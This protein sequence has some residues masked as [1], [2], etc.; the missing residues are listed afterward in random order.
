MSYVLALNLFFGEAYEEVLRQLVNGLKFLGNW[1]DNWEM[2]STSALS[3]ARTRLGEAPIKLLVE[4]IAVPMAGARTR[5]AW[6]R[7]LRVMAIDGLVLDVPA[8]DDNDAE[9]GRSGSAEAPSPFP[10]VRLVALG[11]C[12]TPAV[13]DAAFGPVGTGEQTLAGQLIPRFTAGMLVLADRNFYSYQAWQQA[14]ATG[15]ALL[16]RVSANLRLPV[17]EWL[18]EG[19]YRSVLINPRIRGRRR[20]Q[21]LA[22]RGRRPG[23]RPRRGHAGPGRRVHD[24]QPAGQWGAVLPDHHLGRPRVRARGRTRRG[25][26]PTLGDRA[27]L[28]RDR[29]PPNR[30]RAGAPRPHT[31]TRQTGDLV[32]AARALRDTARHERRRRYRRHRPRRPLLHAKLPRNPPPNSQP[33][34]LFPLTDSPTRSPKPSTRSPKNASDHDGTGHVPGSSKDT[35]RT[36]TASNDQPTESNSTPSRRRS[37]SSQS[38]PNLTALGQTQF[39]TRNFFTDHPAN[40]GPDQ[41]PIFFRALPKGPAQGGNNS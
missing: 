21:L 10:Q 5:A 16:W 39:W 17:L 14:A 30:G 33:G 37:T 27:V 38:G 25:L 26:R 35:G 19:S 31:R 32:T 40:T 41:G 11:E 15:A 8:T 2:P 3:Q 12:G 29:N 4:R 22:A 1:R 18:P 20:E 36:A 34:G 6:C 23:A 24:R 7:G 28:R 13:T 9:F